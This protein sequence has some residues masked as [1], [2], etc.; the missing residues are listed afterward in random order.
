MSK[1]PPV[2]SA[3][4]RLPA[5][6]LPDISALS[7]PMLDQLTAAMNV[8]RNVLASDDQI[9]H[10]WEQIPRL[11]RRIP[12]ELRD[13]RIVRMCVAVA[14]GLFDAAIN[15][16]WN[17]AI[18]ELREK[19]RR[20]GINVVPQILDDKAFDENSLIE[21][22]DAELLDLCRKLNLIGD[23]DFF[24]LDQCRATR[25]SFSVAHPSDGSLDEDEFL[26]FL[27]RC[28]KHALSSAHNPRGVDTKALLVAL[29]ASRFKR[30]QL[31]EWVRRVHETFD[32]Q[33][34]L[35]FVMLH[36]IYCDPASG[37]ELR[38]NAFSICEAFAEEFSP[39]TKS[40]LVDRHQEYTA[41]GDAGRK[42]ASL[43]FFEQLGQLSSLNDAEVHSVV[44]AASRNLLS[45]HNDW[46]NFYNEPPFAERLA[47]LARRNRIPESAQAVFVEAVVTSATGNSYGVSRAATPYYSEMVRSFSPGELKLMLG[48]PNGTNLIAGRIRAFRDCERRFRDLVALVDAKSVPTSLKALYTKW[49]P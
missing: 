6:T 49:L 11:I 26:A 35:I 1:N 47:R 37:Q 5:V 30:D 34:E 7:S 21:L 4:S 19:V 10:A 13:E 42:K 31:E 20:F 15:Y 22:K 39:K 16:V 12:P 24:F 38:L 18:L 36:G 14:S 17:A 48:L 25:N 41:K 9:M 28:Q 29:K 2:K 23:D 46:H 40:A 33:R 3:L 44:T 8:P 43:Q 45:A 32:A 27:S